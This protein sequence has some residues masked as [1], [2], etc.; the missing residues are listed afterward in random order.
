MYV[1]YNGFVLLVILL[2]ERQTNADCHKSSLLEVNLGRGNNIVM[3]ILLGNMQKHVG[4]ASLNWGFFII[5]IIF[6]MVV[7][8]YGRN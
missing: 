8:Y 5:K 6:V 2:T 7:L 4:D 3:L 1:I